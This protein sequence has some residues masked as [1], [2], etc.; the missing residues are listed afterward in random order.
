MIPTCHRRDP[1]PTCHRRDFLRHGALA[2]TA[3][4]WPAVGRAQAPASD[5]KVA[6]VVTCYYRYSHADNIVTRF[7]EGYSIV[8]KSYPPPCRVASLYIDQY[9]ETDIGRPLAKRWNVPVVPTIADALT[10]GTGRLAVD[11]VLLIA[12]QGDYPVN[13]RGQILYPR[14]KFFEEIVR[15]FRDSGRSVPV[16]VDKHLSY[17]WEN[18]RWMYEQSKELGFAMMAGSSVPVSW[19]RPDL[20]PPLGVAWE[21]AVANGYGHFE[22]YGFHTLEGLQVML[23]RRPGGETGVRAVQCLEGR[24]AWEAAAAGR[25]SQALLEAAQGQC[26]TTREG[27]VEEVDHDGIVYLIEYRDGLKAAAFISPRR[28][29]EFAFAGKIKGQAQPAACWYELPKPQRDHFSFLV[30]HIAQMILTGKPAYPVERTL[31]TTGMLAALVESKATKHRR[32]ETPHLDVR[33]QLA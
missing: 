4:W 27:K 22:V 31:L 33:Y 28:C 3:A 12:E 25:W 29:R 30:Q 8:G 6:A 16:F 19:R 32:I 10:L 24:E 15:V 23:E 2:A 11:G 1:I 5:K 14:R 17:S 13:E 18:A 26:P 7:M 21:D 20:R 9:P